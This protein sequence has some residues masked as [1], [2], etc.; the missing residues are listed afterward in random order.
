MTKTKKYDMKIHAPT[1]IPNI[2]GRNNS[3]LVSYKN[4]QGTFEGFTEYQDIEKTLK[5][6]PG[7]TVMQRWQNKEKQR[8]ILSRIGVEL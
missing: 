2:H 5:K 7:F 8:Y 4:K 1:L 6:H 3:V